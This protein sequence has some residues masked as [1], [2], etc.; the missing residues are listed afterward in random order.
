MTKEHPDSRQPQRPLI[1][2]CMWL[3]APTLWFQRRVSMVDRAIQQMFF[4]YF[5]TLPDRVWTLSVVAVTT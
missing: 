3:V 4:V 2:A 1:L 5:S